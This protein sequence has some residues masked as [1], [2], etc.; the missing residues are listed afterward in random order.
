MDVLHWSDFIE[1]CKSKKPNNFQP[2]VWEDVYTEISIQMDVVNDTLL[3]EN[4]RPWRDQFFKHMKSK[5]S[6][7]SGQRAIEDKVILKR[8]DLTLTT[9]QPTAEQKKVRKSLDELGQ[10]QLQRRTDDLW[11]KVIDFASQNDETPFRIVSLLL[12]RCGDRQGKEFGQQVW[13]GSRVDKMVSEDSATAILVDC[14]LGR[15]TYGRLRK[16]LK[17]EGHDILPPWIN[18]RRKQS[19]VTPEIEPLTDPHIGFSFY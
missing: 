5:Q 8:D 13:S 2:P 4:V 9:C 17:K 15:E 12:S 3:Q 19:K 1:I 11:Q 18:L 14:A 7:N 16:I 10:K 6:K